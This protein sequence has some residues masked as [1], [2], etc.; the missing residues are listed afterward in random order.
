MNSPFQKLLM[1][2]ILWSAAWTPTASFL[3]L[4]FH[5]GGLAIQDVFFVAAFV[6]LGALLTIPLF[7][8]FGVRDFML[9]GIALSVI[10]ILALI[11]LPM[12]IAPYAHMFLSGTTCFLFWVPFNVAYYEFRKGNNAQLGA[13]YYSIGPILSLA[14]PALGGLFA[15]S[16]GFTA[17][18]SVSLA[19]FAV[20]AA[21]TFKFVENRKYTY[22]F[23]GSLR[24][25]SG[26]K[27]MVFLEGFAAAVIVAVTLGVMLLQFTDKPSE[28]GILSSLVTVF[29][30]AATLVTAKISDKLQRRRELILPLVACFAASAIFAGWGW[31]QGLVLFLLGYGLVNF[32][33]RIFFPLPFALCVDNSKNL[34]STMVGREIMLNL[35][36]LS[37][38]IFGYVILISISIE[39]ALIAQGLVLLLYIPLFENRKKKL[40]RH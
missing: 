40:Q 24:A 33:S 12:P 18:F 26:L 6:Y 11:A 27:T 37:G 10:S 2:Y 22:S 28:F 1:V 16:F 19:L 30:V 29:A 17:L 38:V 4:Y 14:I 39:A 36:R 15:E 23:I 13:I 34:A 20:A 7:R 9:A 3:Y 31:A 8:G 32:F 25:I 21:A 35:G 5:N